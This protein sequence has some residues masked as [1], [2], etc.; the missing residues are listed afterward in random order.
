MKKNTFKQRLSKSGLIV[1]R[2]TETLNYGVYNAS[3][4]QETYTPRLEVLQGQQYYAV[5]V[6][7][8]VEGVHNGSRG[9]LFH[10][11]SEL[12]RS[13]ND[14]DGMPVVVNHPEDTDGNFIS[15]NSPAVLAEWGIGKLRNVHMADGKLKGEAWLSVQSLVAKEPNLLR[16]VQKGDVIEVSVGVYCDEEDMQGDWNGEHYAAIARNHRPDHL[17]L[18]PGDVGACSVADGCGLRVNSQSKIDVNLKGGTNVEIHVNHE[19]RR[20]VAIQGY[21]LQPIVQ[22]EGLKQ[23]LD[24]V[25]DSL[26][27]RDS[28]TEMYYLEEVYDGYAIYTKRV[29]TK[30]GETYRDGGVELIRENYQVNAD[31]SLEWTQTPVK[32][33]RRVEYVTVPQTMRRAKLNKN[34]NSDNMCGTCKEK[35]NGLIA[36]ANTHFDEN[37]REWLEALTEDKLDKLIPKVVQ[38]NVVPSLV[39]AWKVVKAQAQPA[40]YLS[41]VPDDVKLQI[42]AV[43]KEKEEREAVTTYLTTSSDWTVEELDAMSLNALKKLEAREKS[44]P[45]NYAGAAAGGGAQGAAVAGLQPLMPPDLK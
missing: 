33:L 6:I 25:R 40:D 8:M 39:D 38:V 45:A 12:E 29:R 14:W 7:M 17:A 15:A 42:N 13:V 26:Y 44:A 20:A 21:S 36:H 1:H 2:D 23:L 18:L 10:A 3:V 43:A 30:Q 16:R 31:G 24:L 32:V 5:P 34:S 27:A 37:D 28:D 4:M 35:V 41:N 22:A 11:A 19:S 9:P